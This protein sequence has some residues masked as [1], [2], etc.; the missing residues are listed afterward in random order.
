[1]KTAVE[2]LLAVFETGGRLSPAAGGRLRVLLPSDSPTDLR[3]A[4]CIHKPVL[5]TLVS[6]PQFIVV[7]SEVLQP[8]FLLWVATDCDRDLLISLGAPPELIYA[9]EELAAIAQ[10]NPDANSLMLLRQC[11]RLF[12]SRL[13][14][15]EPGDEWRPHRHNNS[16]AQQ[17][18]SQPSH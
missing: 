17:P 1:M 15:V 18:H 9:R 14:T 3:A 10:A 13:L 12:G 11:K 7:R 4:I 2:T 16:D 6:S 8:R 5:L